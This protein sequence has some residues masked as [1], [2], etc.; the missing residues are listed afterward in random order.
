MSDSV[1]TVLV[2]G[3]IFYD[4][5]TTINGLIADANNSLQWLF[6]VP[7]PQDSAD[8][9]EADPWDQSPIGSAAVIV[10]G[11]TTYEWVIEQERIRENP[12]RWTELFGEK[13]VYVFSSRELWTPP[14]SAVRVVAGAVSDHLDEIRATAGEGNIWLVGGG[15]L[16]GQFLDAD[17]VDRL[18]FSVAPVFLDSGAPLLPRRIE[19]D[20]LQLVDARR[21]GAFARLEY[22]VNRA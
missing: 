16:V 22:R 11:S 8:S 13:P 9:S 20:R 17:A 10:K 18:L 6:D 4:T 7:A 15:D 14:G 1:C 2:M 5:A 12:G 3:D 21:D 19:S